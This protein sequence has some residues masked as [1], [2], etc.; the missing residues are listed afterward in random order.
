MPDRLTAF[1]GCEAGQVPPSAG[2]TDS[3]SVAG[4][5][6]G[7]GSVIGV[8]LGAGAGF[9]SGLGLGADFGSGSVVGLCLEAGFGSGLGAGSDL[10]LGCSSLSLNFFSS[11]ATRAS[12]A[13][14][15][16]TTLTNLRIRIGWNF[17]QALRIASIA[18]KNR[19]TLRNFRIA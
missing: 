13:T 3:L 11:T 8:C 6:V 17:L 15:R 1:T 4:L 7:S 16:N 5:V 12:A 2:G 14:P 9:G 18:S 19:N 10:S